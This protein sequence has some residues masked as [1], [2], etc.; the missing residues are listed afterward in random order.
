MRICIT[1]LIA[2]LAAPGFADSLVGSWTLSI[3]SPR[4]VQTPLLVVKQ[5]GD[6]LTGVYHSN[7]GV[8][9]IDVIDFDGSNFSFP[10]VI[11]VPIGKINVQ[12]SGQISGDDMQG[13]VE[14]P[15]GQVPFTG[16]RE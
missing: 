2:L 10:L 9:A 7:R 14:N 11:E 4:G 12:Y 6:A 8:L 16:R 3:D 13:V 15:R 5:A 1:A